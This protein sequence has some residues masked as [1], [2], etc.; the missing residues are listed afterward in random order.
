MREKQTHYDFGPILDRNLMIMSV[1]REMKKKLITRASVAGRWPGW[2][3]ICW[4]VFM[5]VDRMPAL[6]R[7]SPRA[8][9]REKLQT[10]SGGGRVQGA[11]HPGPCQHRV[12]SLEE[13][14][15]GTTCH[16]SKTRERGCVG[17]DLVSQVAGRACWQSS[18]N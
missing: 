12:A 18:A 11:G 14:E 2:L 15:R 9:Q 10:K 7:N 8:Q 1:V 4:V 13:R 6:A 5:D 17:S 3:V 16:L